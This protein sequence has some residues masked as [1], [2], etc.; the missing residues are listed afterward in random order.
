MLPC[1]EEPPDPH[2]VMLHWHHRAQ[3]CWLCHPW[4]PWAMPEALAGE[5][6]RLVVSILR[7]ERSLEGSLG[8]GGGV[9]GTVPRKLR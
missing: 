9:A 6:E 8:A 3:T 2:W 1:A 7:Q 5:W 4:V